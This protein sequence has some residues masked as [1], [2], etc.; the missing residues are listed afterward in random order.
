MN[1]YIIWFRPPIV[2]KQLQPSQSY[3]S[4]VLTRKRVAGGVNGGIINDISLKSLEFTRD[5]FFPFS[6]F[7][8]NTRPTGRQVLCYFI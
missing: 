1:E 8:H 3:T 4:H 6:L 2:T 7:L 5:Y